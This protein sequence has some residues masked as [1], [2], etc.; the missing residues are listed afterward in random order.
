MTT[1]RIP[2]IDLDSRKSIASRFAR[3]FSGASFRFRS[4]ARASSTC[5]IIIMKFYVSNMN[6]FIHVGR[7]NTVYIYIYRFM[8]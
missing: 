6:R 7:K 1:L 4:C 3:R 5:Y 2:P 8:I